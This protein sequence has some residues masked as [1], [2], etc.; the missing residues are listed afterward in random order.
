[1]SDRLAIDLSSVNSART[2]IDRLRE[3][4]WVFQDG[5]P[6][7]A[8]ARDRTDPIAARRELDGLGAAVISTRAIGRFGALTVG[9]RSIGG[10]FE[11]DAV[12]P[13]GS[14]EP[15]FEEK[16]DRDLAQQLEDRE[17]TAALALP[18]TWELTAELDL[19]ALVVSEADVEIRVL[20]NSEWLTHAVLTA[21]VRELVRFVPTGP[22]RRAYVA[23]DASPAHQRHFGAI[24]FVGPT[25]VLT[26]PPPVAPL[27]GEERSRAAIAAPPPSS[28]IRL[29]PEVLTGPWEAVARAFA[30][31]FIASTWQRLASQL[32]DSEAVLEFLGFKRVQVQLPPREALT[33][34]IVSGTIALYQWAF[35]DLSP[36]RL[37]ALR[38]VVSLY[39]NE[40]A[41][42]RPIDVVDSAEV[43]FLGL[44]SDAVAEVIKASRDAQTQALDT[45]RQ[46]LRS[47]QDLAKS[48][49]ERLLASLVAVGAVVAA[50][51]TKTLNDEVGRNLLLIVA[52]FLGILAA[53]AVLVEGPLLSL[54]LGKL[55]DDLRSGNP[56]LTDAQ[57][58]RAL[59][60]PSIAATRLRV[61]VLRF[62]VPLV[63]SAIAAAIVLFGYPERFS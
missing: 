52:V 41:V 26:L 45:V 46:S 43:V 28:L 15:I 63:Y 49:T 50:N 59:S 33:D 4:E 58:S 38:Q 51:A 14:L 23:L 17:P 19:S 22:G 36:D 44:R 53:F 11:I 16:R 3:A 30:S 61:R 57:R 32:H 1:M 34:E 8:I 2:E 29:E 35:Q 31:G 9:M 42:L 39:E 56:M 10:S 27:A 60:L 40:D 47:V 62:A 54:P 7:R 48:A 18:L 21:S 24:S 6:L 25:D 12:S 5:D 37:L 55:E 20:L 13:S